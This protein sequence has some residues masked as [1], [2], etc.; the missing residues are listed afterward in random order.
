MNV[1][2]KPSVEEIQRELVK[3]MVQKALDGDMDAIESVI[4]RL[5]GMPDQNIFIIHENEEL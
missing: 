4:N 5:E 2:N 1:I 3:I